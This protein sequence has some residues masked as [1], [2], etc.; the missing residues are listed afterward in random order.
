V[1]T[2]FGEMLG[3]GFE[4]FV[5]QEL[6]EI[7]HG[8]IVPTATRE[9]YKLTRADMSV[10][11]WTASSASTGQCANATPMIAIHE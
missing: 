9:R 7:V 8:R 4:V 11:S 1:R 2:L 10:G 3:N 5:W 6:Q